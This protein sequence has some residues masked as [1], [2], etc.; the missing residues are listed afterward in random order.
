M[1]AA[2]S[3]RL[4]QYTEEVEF[5]WKDMIQTPVDYSK[6]NLHHQLPYRNPLQGPARTVM[7]FPLQFPPAGSPHAPPPQMLPHPNS[8]SHAR[9]FIPSQRITNNAL[10]FP[11]A[12][13]PHA[14][15]PQMLPPNP[16]SQPYVSTSPFVSSQGYYSN[17]INSLMA[18]GVISLANQAPK[19]VTKSIGTEFDPDIL[20]VRHEY[21]IGALYGDLPR[22]CKTCGLRFK[23]QDEHSR[24]MDWH[25]TKNRSRSMSKNCKQQKPSRKWF[26]SETMWLSG[27]EALGIESAPAPGFLPTEEKK[28]D[29]ELAVPA[30]EDQSTCALCREPFD[31][32]YSD[33][34]EEWMYRGG[35]YLNAP[36]GIITAGIDRSQ[37]GPIIHA[38]CRSESTTSSSQRKRMQQGTYE[39][40]GNQTK[41]MRGFISF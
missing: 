17:L 39:E 13:G 31:E 4:W 22:Q 27:A 7:P 18:Q 36:N 30:E 25:V 34:T 29:E 41:R 8:I 19:Q 21:V 23:S 9:P 2:A 37:L 14:P 11:P 6:R 38:K 32:F 5:D 24:H 33:E 15:P 20:K 12:G 3:Y 26:V 10:Q 16:I 1:A 40:G 35:V 28:E